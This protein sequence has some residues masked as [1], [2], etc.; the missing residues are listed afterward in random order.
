MRTFNPWIGRSYGTDGIG[1]KR[2]LIL[3][4]SHYGGDGCHYPEFTTEV[5][6]GMALEQGPLAFFSRVARLVV[7]GRGGFSE[8]EREDFWQ[9]V[10]FY[11]FIQTSLDEHGD[12]PT[13][14]MWQAAREPFLQT[15]EELKPHLILILGI[16]LSRNLPEIPD[17]ISVCAVR[18][19]S[20]IGF[21][22]DDWQPAV[23]TLLSPPGNA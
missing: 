9:R 8:T 23:Q 7:G 17:E 12:R 13:S 6:Q 3:G 11:N 18:H 16:E 21:S 20:A 2:L 5:I 19:P 1:G 4:E 15:L 22:Y 10:A 14:E